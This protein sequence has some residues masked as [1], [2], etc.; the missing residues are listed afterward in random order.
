VE[1]DFPIDGRTSAEHSL[2]GPLNGGGP[3]LLLSSTSGVSIERR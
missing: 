2:R 1:S 3:R